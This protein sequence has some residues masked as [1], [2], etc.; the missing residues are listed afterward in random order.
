MAGC[1]PV[2]AC[3]NCLLCG[4]SERVIGIQTEA[5]VTSYHQF[6]KYADDS[7]QKGEIR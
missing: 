7:P 3:F 4:M 6:F 2:F 5:A 1:S